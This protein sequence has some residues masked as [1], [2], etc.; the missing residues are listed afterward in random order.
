MRVY[1]KVRAYC[2]SMKDE[3]Q[4][5]KR[6]WE[7]VICSKTVDN[8]VAFA[9]DDGNHG[10]IVLSSNTSEVS[11]ITNM[12]SLSTGWGTGRATLLGRCAPF[13]LVSQ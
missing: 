1:Y 8:L 7:H 6:E 3:K 11:V 12:F 4:D 9:E 5:C 13:S 10:A 2:V